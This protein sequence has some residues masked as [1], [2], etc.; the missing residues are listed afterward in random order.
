MYSLSFNHFVVRKKIT[1]STVPLAI[2]LLTL[3][4]CTVYYS[5]SQCVQLCHTCSH[6]HSLPAAA[7]HTK[8][9]S[10]GSGLSHSNAARALGSSVDPYE[11]ID[12]GSSDEESSTLGQSIVDE[13]RGCG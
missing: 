1:L 11:E 10:T 3:V 9:S 6:P 13:V 8:H 2:T 4:V 12:S 5:P 7:P